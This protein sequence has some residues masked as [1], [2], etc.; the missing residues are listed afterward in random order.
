MNLLVVAGK[1][2]VVGVKEWP[3]ACLNNF[4]ALELS[5]RG[6]LVGFGL[7]V[8]ESDAEEGS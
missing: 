4:R 3:T 1:V 7:E 8:S 2:W 5:L 6:D